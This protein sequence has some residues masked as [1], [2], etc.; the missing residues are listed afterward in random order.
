MVCTGN[1]CRS[2]FIERLLQ[3]QLPA[4]V[5]VSSAGTGALVGHPI[6]PGSLAQL[7]RLGVV[8]GPFAARQLTPDLISTADLVVTATRDH[9]AAVARLQPRAMSITFT[10]GDLADL[11]QGMQ[12]RPDDDPATTAPG[13]ARVVELVAARRGIVPPRPAREVDIIDPF[14]R[15]DAVFAA[16]AEQVLAVLPPVVGLLRA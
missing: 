9:R 15:E 6:D 10:L 3:A 1:V 7:E 14:R 5:E 4:S 13:V 16:M 11:A 8:S 12:E 2:P